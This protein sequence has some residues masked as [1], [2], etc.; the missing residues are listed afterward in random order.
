MK[1]VFIC[2]RKYIQGRGV[3]RETGAYLKLLGKKPLVLWDS[4]VKGI[5]GSSSAMTHLA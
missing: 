1:S 2:P 4:C 5:V 3:L